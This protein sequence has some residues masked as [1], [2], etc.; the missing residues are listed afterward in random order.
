MIEC[1]VGPDVDLE[2]VNFLQA[3]VRKRYLMTSKRIFTPNSK[4]IKIKKIQAMF[5]KGRVQFLAMRKQRIA[6]QLATEPQG[7]K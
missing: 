1:H 2:H 6:M 5:F 4:K 3:A 7:F